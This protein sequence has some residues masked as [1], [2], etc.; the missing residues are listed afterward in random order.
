MEKNATEQDPLFALAAGF[1]KG[2]TR[3]S[4]VKTLGAGN[5]NDTFLAIPEGGD[6]PFILQKINQNVF[7]VPG[8]VIRNAGKVHRHLARKP[9]PLQLLEP[10]SVYG[11]PDILS[12]EDR[13]GDCWRAFRYIADTVS[14]EYALTPA[15]AF[16]A[17]K[18]MGSFLAGLSDMD[19]ATICEVIPHFHDGMWRFRRFEEA[20]REDIV[21]RKEGTALEI[22]FALA[23][24][25]V[26]QAVQSAGFPVRV[27]HNDAKMGNF[28]FD[29][30]KKSVVA[31]IDWDTVMPG[32]LVSDFG[33]MVRT[34]TASLSENDDRFDEVMVRV[35]WFEALVK[36]FIPPLKGVFRPEEL[37]GLLLG[38][39]WIILEQMIRFLGD[40][41]NGDTYYKVRFPGHNLVRARNQMALYRSLVQ[42]EAELN[43][44]IMG[45]NSVFFR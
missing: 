10:V 7:S 14:Y 25:E 41:L 4:E 29:G 39:K 36:G 3:F 35:E 34:M 18:G 13:A 44:V 6:E 17:S 1:C 12:L 38:A 33:D 40:Y 23:G 15:L 37:E 26:F 32:A 9:F 31:V 22:D 5:I 27:V 42:H 16:E 19:P 11:H 8:E 28:L 43:Q 20:V 21:G 2:G 45:V 24:L 30:H